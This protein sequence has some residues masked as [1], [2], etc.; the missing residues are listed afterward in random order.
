MFDMTP[1]DDIHAF[2][3]K[4]L[5]QGTF[6]WET[7]GWPY[8]S[9]L[10]HARSYWDFRHLPNIHFF[11]YTDMLN[12]LDGEMRRMASALAIPINETNW[13]ALVDAARFDNM[14][15]KADQLAPDVD[16][17]AWADNA[18]FFNKGTSGQW[19]DVLDEDDL[20]IYQDVLEKRLEPELAKW[21]QDGGRIAASRET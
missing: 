13:D 11:H 5:T 8:W 21:L 9:M 17:G 14:K 6:E 7:D 1:P 16:W 12:D 2:F 10:N 4:W 19:R 18:R 15:A 3:R 20:M